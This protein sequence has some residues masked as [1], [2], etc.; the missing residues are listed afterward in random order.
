M[1]FTKD[2]DYLITN[3]TYQKDL[4]QLELDK[5]TINVSDVQALIND[6]SLTVDIIVIPGIE[7]DI[8]IDTYY[9]T[10]I[11]NL[12]GLQQQVSELQNDIAYLDLQITRLND[13]L[14]ITPT[15]LAEEIAKVEASILTAGNVLGDIIEDSNT[16]LVEY[17]VFTTSNVIKPLMTPAYESNVSKLLYTAIGIIL[18][19]G[20]G[21][22][23]VLFKHD[24]E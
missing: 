3:Y 14:F 7:Q 22:V 19:A 8:E 16:M 13:V 23:A 18:G 6:E 2:K 17:N 5:A 24:W 4:K 1:F 12:V 9:S 10:L 15:K 20:I 21:T 11:N